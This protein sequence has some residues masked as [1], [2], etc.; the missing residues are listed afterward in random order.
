MVIEV[1][2]MGSIEVARPVKR[3][4][5]IVPGY[6]WIDGYALVIDGRINYPWTS[7]REALA[8]KKALEE[9]L[10]AK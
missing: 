3:R 5:K 6:A 7:K 2:R 8:A 10:Q 9:K 4:G 1:R